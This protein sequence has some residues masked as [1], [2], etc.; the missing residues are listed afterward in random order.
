MTKQV[1]YTHRDC[2]NDHSKM[3][4]KTLAELACDS[5]WTKG[6]KVTLHN[7]LQGKVKVK[8][9]NEVVAIK[10]TNF[11]LEYGWDKKAN[12]CKAVVVTTDGRTLYA[13]A[14]TKLTYP[15]GMWFCSKGATFVYG[16]G[17][18]RVVKEFTQNELHLP[19]N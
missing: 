14:N 16:D 13:P 5:T 19:A 17:N 9:G 6:S 8:I 10:S 4:P 7:E 1:F 15:E 18:E 3:N 11:G 12:K 2:L